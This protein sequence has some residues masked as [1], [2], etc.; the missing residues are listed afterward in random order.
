MPDSRSL[1]ILIRLSSQ[2]GARTKLTDT[3][4]NIFVFTTNT[5]SNLLLFLTLY[6]LD[7]SF[8]Y[9]DISDKFLQIDCIQN[10][11]ICML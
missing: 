8:T 1:L 3:F 9:L 4:Y 7:L 11:D 10:N 2:L 6:L 5:A